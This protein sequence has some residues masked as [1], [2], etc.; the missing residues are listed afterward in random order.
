MAIIDHWQLDMF[1]PLWLSFITPAASG[2][3]WHQR[4][5]ERRRSQRYDGHFTDSAKRVLLCWQLRAITVMPT[6]YSATGIADGCVAV[7]NP[8]EYQAVPAECFQRLISTVT[9]SVTLLQAATSIASVLSG[10]GAVFVYYGSATGIADLAWLIPVRA[11]A[12]IKIQ[13]RRTA[14]GLAT[15]WL[16]RKI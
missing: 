2:G 10:K 11:I 14:A 1:T 5:C 7:G 6:N 15:G 8:V 9:D 4:R 13:A 3:R 16:H 12:L